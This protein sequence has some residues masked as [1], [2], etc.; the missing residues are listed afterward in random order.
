MLVCVAE[1]FGPMSRGST[2]FLSR[3]APLKTAFKRL[4]LLHTCPMTVAHVPRDFTHAETRRA[5]K[6]FLISSVTCRAK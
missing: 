1:I 6:P 2:S 5:G 3:A 4:E